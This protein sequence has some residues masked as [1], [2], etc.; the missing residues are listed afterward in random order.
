MA[1]I[2][3]IPLRVTENSC[4]ALEW[5]RFLE[6][7]AGYAQSGVGRARLLALAPS[8]DAGWIGREHTLVEEMRLLAA[9][10]AG[11]PGLPALF[12]PTD[13]LARARIDGASLEAE[14]IRSAAALA[15]MIAAWVDLVRTPPGDLENHLPEL[16][17][18]FG[19]VLSVSL[20]P[21][22][23]SLRARFLP[24]GTLADDASQELRRIRRE[25][26]HQHRAIENSLRA[27]LRRYSE[28][29]SAQE[30]L[31]TIR[32]ERFVIPVKAEWKR[33]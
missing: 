26:E 6:L 23:E 14:E 25:M 3:S 22:A 32:G 28:S 20:R 7:L 2:L 15:E 1:F 30:D 11:L 27:A 8:A 31:I 16:R 19:E 17:T 9:S 12:D 24:D 5:D 4:S 10:E 33:R 13:L 18:L 21:L 29:G